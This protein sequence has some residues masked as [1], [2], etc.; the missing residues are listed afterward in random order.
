MLRMLEVEF[1]RV[2]LDEWKVS[3]FFGKRGMRMGSAIVSWT[4]KCVVS[5][6]FPHEGE[7]MPQPVVASNPC[8]AG[9]RKGSVVVCSFCVLALVLVGQGR[10][11]L[12]VI[13]SI[14]SYA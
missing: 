14:L 6:P 5:L 3:H 7:E 2:N 4:D 12:I 11:N 8:L 1:E 9:F 13:S 10:L